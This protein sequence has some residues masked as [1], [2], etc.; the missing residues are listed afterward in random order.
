MTREDWQRIKRIAAD[1]RDRPAPA[2]DRFVA[3]ACA[4]DED[5]R[6]QV[7]SLLGSMD[8]AEHLYE[9]PAL[10]GGTTA[11]RDAFRREVPAGALVGPYC[12]EREIGRGGMGSVYLGV[13]ADGAFA[14]RVAVKVVDSVAN[15]EVVHRFRT[16]RQIL[17]ALDHPN[18]AR[19]LDGGSTADG[20]P[21]L[22][23]EYVDGVPIDQFCERH[24]LGLAERLDLF[25]RVA[26]AVHYAHQRLIIHR[27]IKPGNILVAAD[28]TPKLL[29]FGI[30]KVL[31]PD[32]ASSRRTMLRAMTPES[33]SPE[34]VR[35]EPIT[36][37]SDVYALGALL[38][39]LISG[40][41]P[42]GSEPRSEA[43]LLQAICDVVP[44]PP[45]VAR[46]RSGLPP[47]PAGVFARDLDAIVLMALRK[48][49]ERRYGS[50]A[51]FAD[52]VER[53]SGRRP[54]RAAPDSP[55]CR[56]RK[57]V[58]RHR[59]PVAIACAALIAVV[60]GAGAAIYQSAVARREHA[61]AEQRFSDVRRMANSFVFEFHD[62][63]ADL[64]GSLA[65][66]QLVVKRAAGYLDELAA[67]A[68]DDVALQREL[69]TANLRLAD[70]MG[71]GGTS[72]LGDLP[73]AE[74]RYQTA[75]RLFERLVSR[76]QPAAEDVDG[77]ARVHV[78][79]SRLSVLQG[80]LE[81][82]ERR[83]R[84]AVELLLSAP[85]AAANTA[86]PFQQLGFVQ[87]R[88]GNTAA[89]IESLRQ[90]LSNARQQLAG[91]ADNAPLIAR[92]ARIG[93][94]YGDQLAKNGQENEALAV[95]DEARSALDRLLQRE[96]LNSRHRL[97]L[98]YLLNLRGQALQS[99]QRW[100]DASHAFA[101]ALAVGELLQQA[102]PDDH[103]VQ[104][105][106]NIT[107]HWH[108][109]AIAR[110]G[111]TATAVR[112]LRRA[113]KDGE[114]IV[115]RAPSNLFAASQLAAARLELAKSLLRDDPS[116]REGC[117]ALHL[118]LESGRQLET[119][120]QR[121]DVTDT[122]RDH[123]QELATA[124]TSANR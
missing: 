15:E 28:G 44:V 62:A 5:L 92:F 67:E 77:L 2:R 50:A 14:Q 45:L 79:M 7:E 64:P 10:A 104:L 96:P 121:M 19:L 36:V 84:D 52:D 24:N 35:G 63:I 113:V 51:Q 86:T 105:T 46:A 57:F 60:G 76:Q 118:G 42:Y 111:D 100:S 112:T 49:P 65:A 72:N 103:E 8:A 70:I 61:R 27:D 31:E 16:E 93:T 109:V 73:G 13:R 32:G 25:R 41:S 81:T 78:Q 123:L 97:N 91:D 29:D 23:M 101:E 66:R 21:F 33:A 20:V 98:V 3:A 89:A 56:A 102:A 85:H 69:A 74:A 90:A 55:T 48:E 58:A 119:R 26:A 99:Q 71:G 12:I 117:T 124:C 116:S 43:A 110:S 38:Y 9:T 34:Q 83:A 47:W 82:A 107:R 106:L 122:E 120:G 17:A 37:A 53:F 40:Q 88:R 68:N 30:A 6:R 94:D 95:L 4:G 80:D 22:T 54:V 1:A 87:G 11:M 108:A 18:I 59:L 39:R 115:E 75:L 114:A